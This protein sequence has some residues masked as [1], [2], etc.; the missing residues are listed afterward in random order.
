M[1]P[2][3]LQKPMESTPRCSNTNN[4][5]VATITDKPKEISLQ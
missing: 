1:Q 5:Y 2:K 4:Q 3:L